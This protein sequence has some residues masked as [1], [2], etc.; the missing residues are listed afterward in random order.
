MGEWL[1]NNLCKNKSVELF[2]H[3][4]LTILEPTDDFSE[5]YANSLKEIEDR[6]RA[7]QELELMRSDNDFAVMEEAIAEAEMLRELNLLQ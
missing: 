6:R 5:Y 2:E 1:P 4:V 3:D 7:V